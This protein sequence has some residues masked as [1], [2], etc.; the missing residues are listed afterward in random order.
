MINVDVNDREYLDFLS[1]CIEDEMSV[2]EKMKIFKEKLLNLKNIWIETRQYGKEISPLMT[3][4]GF[5]ELFPKSL[6]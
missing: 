6:V 3:L 5:E 2:E 1:V 4:K